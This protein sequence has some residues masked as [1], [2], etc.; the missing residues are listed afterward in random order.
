MTFRNNRK[1][2]N[3]FVFPAPFASLIVLGA[4]LALVYI[5]L[6]CRCDSLGRDLKALEIEGATLSK[7][8]LNEEYRWTRMKAPEN[9]ERALTRLGIAMTWPRRDQVVYL[10]D[11]PPMGPLGEDEQNALTY[12]RRHRTV[13]H[14]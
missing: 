12:V 6:C 1:K 9:M 11:T 14:D 8:F 2:K 10:Y 4:A 3:G 13:M 7:Q 5:W